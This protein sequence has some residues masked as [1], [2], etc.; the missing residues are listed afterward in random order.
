MIVL[1]CS[2]ED[3]K[4]AYID[5]EIEKYLSSMS[6]EEKVG[7]IFMIEISHISP[8]E[9]RDYKIG[10]IL[11]G[12]GSFPYGKADH[13]LEDWQNLAD[14]YFLASKNGVNGSDIPVIWGT[15]AVHGHNNLK[16]A[17][18]YPHNIGLGATRNLELIKTLSSAVQRK[19][20]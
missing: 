11:N 9:V 14:E 5:S 2:E 16:G 13:S 3:S 4:Q 12:G 18:L 10:A 7:Q 6:I 1:T 19:F 15:D 20:I 17:V 8:E